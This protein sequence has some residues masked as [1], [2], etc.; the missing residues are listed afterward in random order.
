MI[1]NVNKHLNW[2][3]I[4]QQASFETEFVSNMLMISTS[5]N[6]RPFTGYPSENFLLESAEM[7]E[8]TSRV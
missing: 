2:D 8:E 4:M 3:F 6:D 1:N 7:A 5:A